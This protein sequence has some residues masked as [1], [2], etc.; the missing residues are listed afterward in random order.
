MHP[1]PYETP[2]WPGMRGVA[3]ASAYTLVALALTAAHASAS[4]LPAEPAT[5]SATTSVEQSVAQSEQLRAQLTPRDYT[6]LAAEI[7]AK[8]RRISVKEGQAF[9]AGQ[10]LIVLDC[11][12]QEAQQHKAKAELDVAEKIYAANRRL[13]ELHSIG[14]VELETSAAE[15]AKARAEAAY[16][17]ATLSKCNIVAPFSGRVAEQK[18]REQQFVQPAQALLDILD[19]S[20]L[21]LEFIV[22]SRWLSWL[23]IGLGFQVAID[24]TGQTYPARITRLGARV[25]AVS[26]SIKASAVIDG[27]F[28]NL[29][30]GMSGRVL[31]VPPQ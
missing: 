19:D 17:N 13:A 5:T 10:V 30:A 22:P 12:L 28:P 2:P 4:G 9:H 14:S 15:V 24:E 23:K 3:G 18:V 25:D 8:V 20:A 16:V 11:T 1:H 26:Q 29:V 21:E 6:T 31:L 27:N 7:S